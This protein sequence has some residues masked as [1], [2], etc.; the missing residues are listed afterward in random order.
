MAQDIIVQFEDWVFRKIRYYDKYASEATD[1]LFVAF[2]ASILDVNVD[3]KADK[4]TGGTEDNFASLDDT[5]NLKDSGYAATSFAT[6]SHNH[7]VRYTRLNASVTWDVTLGGGQTWTWSVDDQAPFAIDNGSGDI[8]A[9]VTHF[10]ADLLDGKHADEFAA[11]VHT[12]SKY[13]Q[14]AGTETITG[15]WTFSSNPPFA[16][17]GSAVNALVTGL[18]ADK[19][20]G[21]DA[22]AFA[23]ASHTHNDLYYTE[24]E[25]DTMIALLLP[26]PNTSAADGEILVYDD[27]TETVSRSGVDLS[28]LALV[29]ALAAKADKLDAGVEDNFM[30]FD[31]D[32]NIKDS[33]SAAASFAA[34]SHNHDDRYYTET[35]QTN[36]TT[37]LGI[38]PQSTIGSGTTYVVGSDE[39]TGAGVTPNGTLT[40]IIN[41]NAYFLLTSLTA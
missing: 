12:H 21:N 5:G 18:N 7:D 10:N 36:H 28:E 34:A 31:A 8:L 25:I 30:A 19:L 17:S 27:A 26:I 22:T 6:A 23:A 40:V 15:P 1:A 41:G 11:A 20:D 29:S 9:V 32:G 13:A 37:D 16:L 2:L 38:G 35:Q 24:D 33:G 14:K 3:D 4:V 39:F